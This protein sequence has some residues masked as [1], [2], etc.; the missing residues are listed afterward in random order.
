MIYIGF[1]DYRIYLSGV[2]AVWTRSLSMANFAV[3]L[4]VIG[5]KN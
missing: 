1:A 2:M 4:A 5:Q 3:S